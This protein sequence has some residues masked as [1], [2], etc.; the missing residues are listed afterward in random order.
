M[1]DYSTASTEHAVY[2]IGGYSSLE[3][4]RWAK[5]TRTIAEYKDG[6]WSKIGEMENPRR[7]HGSISFGQKLLF[8][9]GHGNDAF[10]NVEIWDL[11]LKQSLLS[12]KAPHLNLHTGFGMFLVNKNFCE[13]H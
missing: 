10:Q 9:E 12:F 8:F 7:G 6:I 3:G 5:S 11:E 2:I 1:Y 4:Q 13:L